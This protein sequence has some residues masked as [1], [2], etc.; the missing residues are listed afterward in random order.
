MTIPGIE[1]VREEYQKTAPKGETLK[2]PYQEY[3][4]PFDLAA[5]SLSGQSKMM[6]SKMLTDKFI[7]SRI[8]ILGQSTAIYASH[9]VGKT[10]FTLWM[11][12]DAVQNRGV[13]GADIFY[14]NADDTFRGLVEKN[15]FAEE[16]G[17]HMLAPGHNGFKADQLEGYIKQMIASGTA[18][19]KVLVLDTV[20]KFTD[21]MN[22]RAASS[23]SEIVRQFV[24]HGGTVI[25]LAHVNKHRNAEQQV[26][27]SG[28]TDLVDDADCAYTLDVVT[29]EGRWRTVKFEN[30]KARGDVAREV[31]YKYDFSDGTP[32]FDRLNSI[33]EVGG[34]ER[35]AAEKR[36]QQQRTLEKNE[37]A[38]VVIIE[39]V[40]EGINQK[41]ALIKEASS[42]SGISKQRIIKAL[43]AHN[44]RSVPDNQFWHVVVGDKN[45]HSY[46]LNSGV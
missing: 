23:F 5:F 24:S 33:A 16:H 41:T 31:V 2:Q 30:F 36:R 35:K 6:R 13:H 25:M 27:Y 44:G 11:I 45:A 43:N 7:M 39:V 8:A 29:E 46:H 17:F 1:K 3:E 4:K 38:V 26:V 37:D 15:E 22:K 12:R 9:N 34:E 14:I 19:G 10:V 20:K 32:Y 18:A 21:L 40:R 42:R 28:T